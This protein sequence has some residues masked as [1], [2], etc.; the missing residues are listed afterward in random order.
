VG[1]FIGVN[2]LFILPPFFKEEIPPFNPKFNPVF[3]EGNHVPLPLP[4][5]GLN[6]NCNYLYVEKT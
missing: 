6:E 4:Q 5:K 2:G 3:N 1:L